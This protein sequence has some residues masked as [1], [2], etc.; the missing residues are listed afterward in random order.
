MTIAATMN[1]LASQNHFPPSCAHRTQTLIILKISNTIQFP[2]NGCLWNTGGCTRGTWGLF[3]PNQPSDTSAS[4]VK[5]SWQAIALPIKHHYLQGADLVPTSTSFPNKSP[6]RDTV[7]LFSQQ[8]A[9]EVGKKK[10]T[11]KLTFQLEKHLVIPTTEVF[12]SILGTWGPQEQ[13]EWIRSG[14]EAHL[15]MEAGPGGCARHIP[16]CPEL[17]PALPPHYAQVTSGPFE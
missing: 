2:S 6:R 7:N 10:K 13:A 16:R 17:S 12:V 11:Q 15:D 1:T 4:E 8:R 3:S 9:L 5:P 14:W